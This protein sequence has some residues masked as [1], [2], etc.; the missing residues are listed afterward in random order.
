MITNLFSMFDPATSLNTSVNWVILLI[1]LA[2]I[3]PSYWVIP[4]NMKAMFCLVMNSLHNEFSQPLSGKKMEGVS[5]ILVSTFL[6]ICLINITGLLSY[7]FPATSHISVS[8]VLSLLFWVA[9]VG[10]NFVSRQIDFM[11]H[12]VPLGTPKPLM[13]FMVVIESIS[14]V[15][16]SITLCVRLSA[17]IIA[18]HLI[19]AIIANAASLSEWFLP[20]ELALTALWIL[21]IMVAVVQSYVFV[22]LVSIYISE[23]HE[24][25]GRSLKEKTMGYTADENGVKRLNLTGVKCNFR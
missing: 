23:V 17:N 18:G 22:K 25:S 20:I 11:A 12:L 21:E 10:N 16:R 4:R 15:I 2:L 3:V 8:L 7:V 1:P 14:L 24:G 9:V 5:A 19:I 13:F 6:F